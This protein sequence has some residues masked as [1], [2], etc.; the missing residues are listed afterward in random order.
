MKTALYIR[1]S[2]TEQAKEGYSLAFQKRKMLTY[3]EAMEWEVVN[4]YADEGI[5]GYSVEKRPQIKQLLEDA[6]SKKFDAV[7]IMKIDRLGRNLKELLSIV[8]I[9]QKSDVRLVSVNEQ[10][11]CSTANGRMFLNMLGTLAEFEREVISERFMDGKRQKALQGIKAPG[12]CIPFGYDYDK[13]NKCFVK[14]EKAP[15]V[16][17]IFE[18]AASGLT[19]NQIATFLRKNNYPII[20]IM[21][22]NRKQV[23]DIVRNKIYEGHNVFK[24]GNQKVEAV[25]V[26]AKNI[27]PIVSEELWQEANN[28]RTI[29]KKLVGNK[30]SYN[31]F[32][33]ADVLFCKNCGWK[34]STIKAK[35]VCRGTPKLEYRFYRYYRCIRNDHYKIVEEL[36]KCSS[37]IV[38]AEK[39]EKEF[40]EFIKNWN[41]TINNL[42]NDNNC[43]TNDITSYLKKLDL[44]QKQRQK[45]LDKFLNELIDDDLYVLKNQEL[46]NEIEQI[47]KLINDN[48]QKSDYKAINFDLE[49]INGLKTTIGK[50]WKIM[51]DAEKR[52]FITTT[53]QKIIIDNGKIVEIIFR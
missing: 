22:W 45:L 41:I 29:R 6:K 53:F 7:L 12:R 27:Q 35:R 15:I 3:C 38:N 51:N 18:K 19:F 1:V 5:S 17:L 52:K 11:D 36:T 20:D 50:L 14:N 43:D 46:S 33:F 23:Y 4:I 28:F 24:I 16:K 37:K 42:K 40:L 30:Y 25:D 44:L 47:N 21:P 32:I 34:M 10:I 2:T 13:T 48:N 26:V 39:F 9:L 31:D 8:E 49:K